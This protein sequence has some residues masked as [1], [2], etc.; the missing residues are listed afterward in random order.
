M[1]WDKEV[2]QAAAHWAKALGV[3]I[4]PAL[5]HAVIERESGHGQ[6][7][8][9]V[10]N[11]GVVPE[12][13]GHHSYGPMQL[14]DDTIAT[15]GLG[16]RP[17]DL[18]SHPQLGIW[19]GVK[20]L[21][22]LLQKFRGDTAAAISAYNAGAGNAK[23]SSTGKFPNQGYVDFVLSFWNR[24]KGLVAS[25]VPVVLLAAGLVWFLMLRGRRR[26]AA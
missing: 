25:V 6:A 2:N 20:W 5:V 13:G 24:N 16:I 9:Y 22:G 10:A 1:N 7:P 23:R 4:D 3:A 11:H 18:A 26:A 15:M 8:N 17:E 14:Y 12:P 21:G 19:Y